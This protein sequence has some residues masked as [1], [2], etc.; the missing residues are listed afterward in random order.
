MSDKTTQVAVLGG[1]PAGYAAAFKCAD[2]GLETTLIDLAP[3]P[4][5]VCL[6]RGCIPSKALL[7][8][9]KLINEAAEAGNWGIGFNKPEI[10][11]DKLRAWKDSV[12]E[13]LTGGLGMLRKGRGVDHVQGRGTLK[14]ANTI[15]VAL[16]DGG[17]ASITAEHIIVAVGSHPTQ[18]PG[19][20][21]DSERVLDSTSGL[22]L[23]AIPGSLLVIGGGYIGLELGSVYASLGS[24]V[25][26][27]EMTDGLLPGADRDLVKVLQGRLGKMFKN[28]MFNTRVTKVE[29][30]SSGLEV[31]FDGET[32]ETI[33]KYD[34]ILVAV[35]R[36]P[37]SQDLGLENAGIAVNDRGFVTVDAQRRTN[38]PNIFAVGDIAGEPML[39]HKGSH[40]GI[41]AA[42]V[43]AGERVAFEAEAIPAVVFTDPELAWCGLT[44]TEAAAAGREVNVTKFPWA[45]SGRAI[46]I[47]RPDGLTKILFDPETER[48]LGVGICGAGAGEMIA[49]GVLAVEMAALATDLKLSIHPHPTLSETIMEAAEMVGGASTHIYRPKK[50]QH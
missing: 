9:S 30:A 3:N 45:A 14:D 26:V 41:V 34:Y 8:V 11:L 28:I 12:I 15:E 35:G 43:I 27:V 48:V 36:R 40:E 33:Q 32:D 17:A 20:S 10:D 31:H 24:E 5:G 13:Q 6:Y 16:S 4:G 1:G 44:E 7:H 46:S 49:E 39:A 50:K 18:I 38:V 47:D 23:P 29:E 2:L 22:D 25:S 42:E 19:I 21:I 37:N